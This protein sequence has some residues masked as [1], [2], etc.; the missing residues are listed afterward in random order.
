MIVLDVTILDRRAA[1]ARGLHR[2]RV[3]DC[4]AC[5]R[6]PAMNRV[7]VGRPERASRRHPEPREGLCGAERVT[8]RVDAGRAGRRHRLR[9]A[10]PPMEAPTRAIRLAPWSRRYR[11]G[12]ARSGISPEILVSPSRTPRVAARTGTARVVGEGAV[13]GVGH[14]LARPRYHADWSVPAMCASIIPAVAS[15]GPN[16]RPASGVPSRASIVTS[17]DAAIA[18]GTQRLAPGRTPSLPQQRDPDEGPAGT[19]DEA[20][21][22]HG[23]PPVTCPA[24]SAGAGCA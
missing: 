16:T 24:S 9:A 10:V 19:A 7:A 11:H 6:C 22:A 4:T 17:S 18:L 12:R 5:P 20:T 23:R 3:V 8:T 21:D 1:A 13:A 15:A 2:L 14:P